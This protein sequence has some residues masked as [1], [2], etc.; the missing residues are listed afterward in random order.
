MLNI[1]AVMESGTVPLH[2][3]TQDVVNFLAVKP[4]PEQLRARTVLELRKIAS[5]LGV[6]GSVAMS[7][8]DCEAHTLRY[9]G[10]E[11]TGVTSGGEEGKGEPQGGCLRL[12]IMI[13]SRK[14]STSSLV[15]QY[16]YSEFLFAP[17]AQS[18]HATEC[19]DDGGPFG[20]ESWGHT[21]VGGPL[22]TGEAPR[23]FSPTPE[24]SGTHPLVT[25]TRVPHQTLP[26]PGLVS[27]SSLTPEMMFQLELKKLEAREQRVERDGAETETETERVGSRANPDRG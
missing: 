23:A 11:G 7:K 22:P 9:W 8:Q 27:G 1:I 25:Q 6:P 20:R 13:V 18:T 17:G 4:S 14:T 16:G 12:Q 5:Y 21:V 19:R 10:G 2:L 24:A 26:P 3:I 15:L